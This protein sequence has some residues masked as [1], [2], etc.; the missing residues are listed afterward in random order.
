M[1]VRA[2]H[3]SWD[4]RSNWAAAFLF[5][6]L[7]FSVVSMCSPVA[8]QNDE[9]V[10]PVA[11]DALSNTGLVV[12]ASSG[13]VF[14]YTFARQ[15]GIPTCESLFQVT[16]SEPMQDMT[17]G[18]FGK[19][20]YLFVLTRAADRSRRS[21][22]H[23]IS[24]PNG[25]ELNRWILDDVATGIDYDESED[26]LYFV[27]GVDARLFRIRLAKP[28]IELVGTLLGVGQAGPLAVL[29]GR[30]GSAFG[31]S[32]YVGDA[33]NGGIYEYQIKSKFQGQV[34]RYMGAVTALLTYDR[35][36]KHPTL[37][38]ADT[39]R[40]LV[41]PFTVQTNG[42]LVSGT[43]VAQGHVTLPSSIAVLPKF[44]IVADRGSNSLVVFSPSWQFVRELKYG[45]RKDA[46]S[47]PW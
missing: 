11:V 32:I 31:T 28:A 37:F 15:D 17:F 43:W 42:S 34:A 36:G 47:A 16:S 13:K 20:E 7:A 23:Q 22:I 3:C 41:V 35:G 29:P 18:V 44:N 4:S 25:K 24:Y 5:C 38:A 33:L 10:T 12:L 1:K 39:T 40:R 9:I 27:T 45:Q 46:N 2:L 6:L 8:A 19:K 26:T 21:T 14:E 30:T